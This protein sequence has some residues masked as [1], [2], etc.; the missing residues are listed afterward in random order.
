MNKIL[1]LMGLA[2][3]A[4][5]LQ[6]GFDAAIEAIKSG[7]AK[8]A[9]AAADISDKTFSNLKFEADRH[10]IAAI[11][12]DETTEAVSQAIGKKA[13]VIAICDEGFFKSISGLAASQTSAERVRS[14]SAEGDANE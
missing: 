6:C 9:A 1:S 3:R 4:G 11:R 7:N 5:K 12:I 2:R 13:G 10:K 8:G 14:N